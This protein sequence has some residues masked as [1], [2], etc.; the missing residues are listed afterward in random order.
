MRTDARETE[1]INYCKRSYREGARHCERRDHRNLHRLA[2]ERAVSS[3]LPRAKTTH[4]PAVSLDRGAGDLYP[5]M[6][7][8]NAKL[9]CYKIN[10]LL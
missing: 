4:N 3:R 9:I 8:L 2:P 6:C 5:T 10:N 1:G 7:K